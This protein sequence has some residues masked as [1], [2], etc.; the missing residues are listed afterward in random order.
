MVYYILYSMMFIG[1]AGLS[2]TAPDV[3]SKLV[4]LCLTLANVIFFYRG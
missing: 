1:F 4:G 3:K 2:L